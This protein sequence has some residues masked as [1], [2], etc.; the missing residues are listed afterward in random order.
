VNCLG[1]RERLAEFALDV[2]EPSDASDVERHL[3]SCAGCRKE[4]EELREGAA[5]LAYDLPTVA[6]STALGAR[7]MGRV[8]RASGPRRHGH[9]RRA[10]RAAGAAG[11][12][13]A[14]LAAGALA[15]AV[16]NRDMQLKQV[17][18]ALEKRNEQIST[19]A[20]LIDQLRRQQL[21]TGAV[22]GAEFIPAPLVSGSGAAVI[23]DRRNGEDSL[24]LLVNVAPPVKEPIKALLQEDG[25][26]VAEVSLV[27]GPDGG[28]GLKGAIHF[29]DQELSGVSS[30]LVV[31]KAGRTLLVGTVT[32]E[33]SPDTR[34]N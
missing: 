8:V 25:S 6:P 22:Y 28:Y 23:V 20:Q 29:F 3:E 14:I 18:S 17:Q 2:L 7:V 27:K 1:Y 34:A 10:W 5:V 26:P 31:D 19:L 21:L 32:L 24:F 11:L 15:Q 30:I 13:A 9:A 33:P 12:A 4:V 16:H